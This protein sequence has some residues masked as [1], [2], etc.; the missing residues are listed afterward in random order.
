[1]LVS[2]DPPQVQAEF[3]RSRGW[4]YRMISSQGSAFKADL[5]FQ[6]GDHVMPGYSTFHRDGDRI[7]NVANDYFGPGD[8]YCGLWHMFE[9]L[10][11]GPGEWQ[12]KFSY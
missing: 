6:S 9:L 3:A 8:S 10:D 12:P 1:M 11:G 7:V 2:P 5:G 4:P